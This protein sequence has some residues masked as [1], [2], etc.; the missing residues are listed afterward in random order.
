MGEGKIH[1]RRGSELEMAREAGHLAAEI[2]RMTAQ[3][4][5]PGV[6]TLEVEEVAVALMRE[7]NCRS[8]FYQYRKFPGHICISINDEVVHGIAS[9]DRVIMQ[10]DI[11]KI[12]VGIVRNG[13]IGDNAVTVPVGE[14][15]PATLHLLWATEESLHVGISYARDG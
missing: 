1:I 9:A 2:L 12:D 15:D 6:T 10:G 11:V 5:R 7:R 8:A 4:V 3:A 14:V 13:W